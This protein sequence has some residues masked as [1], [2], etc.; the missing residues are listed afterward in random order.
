ML[1]S[2]LVGIVRLRDIGK[3][4]A[5]LGRSVALPFGGCLSLISL[6]VVF[7]GLVS[8]WSWVVVPLRIQGVRARRPIWPKLVLTQ[9]SPILVFL[10]RIRSLV[11]AR[12]AY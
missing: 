7:S 11:F 3:L 4:L 2:S 6:C 5:R 1:A 10:F 9:S 8:P 12:I